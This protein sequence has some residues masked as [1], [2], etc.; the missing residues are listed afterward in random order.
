MM[1]TVIQELGREGVL[2]YASFF[3]SNRPFNAPLAGLFTQYILSCAFML[4]PPPGD[5]YL[6]MISLS[7]YSLALINALVSAGLLLLYTKAYQEWD[8]DPPFQAPKLIIWLFFLS[9]VFLVVIPTIPPAPGS[10]VYDYLPYW[11][12]VFV[13]YL[14]SLIGIT[15][16]YTWCIWLPKRKGYKLQRYWVL[17]ANGVSRYVFR[18]VS[19]RGE[20][21]DHEVLDGHLAG[22]VLRETD[23]SGRWLDPSTIRHS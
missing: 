12:H 10:R 5:A 11:L 2:P 13:A 20:A 23:D 19:L 17:H 16:W 15:Y 6:F 4:A 3:A 18:A 8:W 22:G 14:V 7:S 1:S 21:V 9:N